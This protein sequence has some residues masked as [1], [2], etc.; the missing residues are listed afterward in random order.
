MD[1]TAKVAE[2]EAIVQRYANCIAARNFSSA[3]RVRDE[4]RQT[5]W[6]ALEAAQADGYNAA[7][8]GNVLEV[9]DEGEVT[10]SAASTMRTGAELG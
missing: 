1:I 2:L 10:V 6:H 3:A 4:W 7:M 5:T 9:D 8:V